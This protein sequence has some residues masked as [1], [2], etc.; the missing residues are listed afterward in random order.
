MNKQRFSRFISCILALELS[1]FTAIAMSSAP[2]ID[3]NYNP[4]NWEKSA[5]ATDDAIYAVKNN[6]LRLLGFAL[7]GYSVPGVESGT[8]QKYIDKCGIRIFENFG[9]VVRGGG[10]L[11][12]M[13]QAREYAQEYNAIILDSCS[14]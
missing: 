11:L 6:D 9:D 7:R 1:S 14:L 5:S 10:Q 3:P 13:K 4:A 8:K 2:E 12:Q